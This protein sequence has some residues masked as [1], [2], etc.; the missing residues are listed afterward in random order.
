VNR[1]LVKT[2]FFF[3]SGSVLCTL[4]TTD[5]LRET[6]CPTIFGHCTNISERQY[7]QVPSLR[8]SFKVRPFEILPPR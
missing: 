4:T 5:T 2:S 6:N 1:P 3:E 7:V 8:Q